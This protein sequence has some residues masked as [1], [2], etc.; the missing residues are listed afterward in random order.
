MAL[1]GCTSKEPEPAPG[2]T[3]PPTSTTESAPTSEEQITPTK[4][5]LETQEHK[6]VEERDQNG[7]IVDKVHTTPPAGYEENGNGYISGWVRDTDSNTTTH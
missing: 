2:A 4:H 6:G 3:E 7:H 5:A 1:A